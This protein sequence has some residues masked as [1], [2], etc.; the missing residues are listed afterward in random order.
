MLRRSFSH[1]KLDVPF[2]SL[3]ISVVS[4]RTLRSPLVGIGTELLSH[5][6]KIEVTR[7]RSRCA[8]S[9]VPMGRA[10]SHCTRAVSHFP[11]E[12]LKPE[13]R[14]RREGFEPSVSVLGTRD[15]KSDTFLREVFDSQF[16]SHGL[17]QGR[18]KGTRAEIKPCDFSRFGRART[19]FPP[20]LTSGTR[21]RLPLESPRFFAFPS[22]SDQHV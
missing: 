1:R 19:A 14:W 2:A 5:R 13:T 9:P 16:D 17:G 12:C 7:H 4:V 10:H 3:P 8:R 18:M 22:R 11:E 20:P 15:R 6:E 21:V